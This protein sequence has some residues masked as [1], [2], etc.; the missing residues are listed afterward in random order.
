MLATKLRAIFDHDFD[1]VVPAS[2]RASFAHDDLQPNNFLVIETNGELTISGLIDY[3]NARASAGVM[4]LAKTIFCC[5]HMTPGCT[6]AILDGYGPIDHPEPMRAL[7]FY[8]LLH[9]IIM[10]WWLRHVGILPTADAANDI[11]PALEQ[12]AAGA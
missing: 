9:R 1:R 11:I 2:T 3:G 5:E 10:W 6:A 8:T 7:A 12:T 4:D